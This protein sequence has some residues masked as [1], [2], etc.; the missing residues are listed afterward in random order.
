M[1][2]LYN[3]FLPLL[4]YLNLLAYNEKYDEW[5]LKGY[6]IKFYEFFFQNRFLGQI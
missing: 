2:G 4:K 3:P 5:R 6:E 1:D